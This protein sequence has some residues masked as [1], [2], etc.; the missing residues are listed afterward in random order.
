MSGPGCVTSDKLL[1]LSG[2]Y[3]LNHPMQY[4]VSN[5]C[6]RMGLSTNVRSVIIAWSERTQSDPVRIVFPQ[7]NKKQMEREI[8]SP[9]VQ[10]KRWVRIGYDQSGKAYQRKCPEPGLKPYVCVCVCVC[11]CV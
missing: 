11:V 7:Q 9:Q 5:V 3:L 1:T 6:M 10:R 8:P 4:V 2:P